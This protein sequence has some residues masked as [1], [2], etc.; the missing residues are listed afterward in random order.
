VG[1]DAGKEPNVTQRARVS[2]GSF[3]P[4]G[5][6]RPEIVDTDGRAVELSPRRGDTYV[7]VDEIVADRVGLV[8]APW[9]TQDAG[10]RLRFPTA[11]APR[12]S[13]RRSSLERALADH[14]GRGRQLQR[15]LR[16]G[17]AFWVR[18]YSARSL[19]WESAI[20]VTRATRRAALEAMVRATTYRAVERLPRPKRP[21]R[22]RARAKASGTGARPAQAAAAEEQ[23]LSP[24]TMAPPVV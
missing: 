16:V 19:S 20:D 8:V 22:R 12:R 24:G 18:G 17:D 11:S 13:F 1:G 10:G 23:P 21:R 5:P 9:P 2:D 15:P 14:R 6:W 7:V 4:T 3:R